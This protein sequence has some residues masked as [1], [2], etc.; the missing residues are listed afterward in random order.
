M[1]TWTPL[2][3]FYATFA[4]AALSGISELLHSTR[5]VN[6]R[7]L[8]TAILYSGCVGCSLGILVYE[9]A[10]GKTRPALVVCCGFLVG[11]RAVKLA[12]IKRM[13]QKLIGKNG[14]PD[15]D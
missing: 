15:E 11:V 12:D 4:A 5:E 2:Q 8:L 6:A 1:E 10:G 3:L 9:Y 14:N 7:S 13:V